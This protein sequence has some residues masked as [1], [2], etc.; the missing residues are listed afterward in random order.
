MNEIIL[1]GLR[2]AP[3]PIIYL[4]TARNYLKELGYIYAKMK[5]VIYIDGYER[6]DVVACHKIFLE[7]MDKLKNRMP[8][9]SG[10]DLE[11]VI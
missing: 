2:F 3:S 10:D 8:I 5:K 6:E 7:Q 9:F 4:N 1:P 11:E